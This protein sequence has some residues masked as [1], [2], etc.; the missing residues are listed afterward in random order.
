MTLGFDSYAFYSSTQAGLF[1]L[2]SLVFNFW[3]V[4]EDAMFDH[5]LLL[6]GKSAESQKMPAGL[7]TSV[8]LH[9]SNC[10]PLNGF[11]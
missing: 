6:L 5:C 7:V 9:I 3:V 2:T 1:S 4:L 8:C 10:L 11:A